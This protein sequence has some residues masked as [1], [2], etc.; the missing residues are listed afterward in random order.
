M[1]MIKMII[2]TIAMIT[3]AQIQFPTPVEALSGSAITGSPL[4]ICR[5]AIET[6]FHLISRMRIVIS[7]WEHL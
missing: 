3:I 6:I 1:T 5:A 2:A 4:T 7:G